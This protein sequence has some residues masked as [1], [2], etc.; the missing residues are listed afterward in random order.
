MKKIIINMTDIGYGANNLG[1]S[2]GYLQLKKLKPELATKINYIE[3]V[4]LTEDMTQTNKKFYNTIYNACESLYNKNV[5]DLSNDN[6][7]ITIGGDHSLAL[8]SVKASIAHAGDDIGLVWIDAHADI[9]TFEVTESGNIHGTPVASLLGINDQHYNNLGNSGSI[10]PQN[11]VYF[12]TRSV[13][14]AEVE[15]INQYNIKEIKDQQISNTSFESSLAEMVSYLEGKVSKIHISL[16]LDSISP[17]EIS[18]VST[19]V[20]GGLATS[21]PLAIIKS[22]NELFD[23]VAIDI[24]EY[25][26][27]NDT[28]N[29]TINYLENLVSELYNIEF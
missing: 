23:V 1:I 29:Q 25:N 7:V 10:K 18:G 26:P 11:L 28:N 22:L 8:G 17:N 16:D 15:L 5:E 19:P 9:N 21:H 4:A 13:D 20:T 3:H 14:D 2:H 12:A 6:L 27:L 24:V